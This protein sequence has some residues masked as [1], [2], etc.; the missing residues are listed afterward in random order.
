VLRW[1][2][3]RVITASKSRRRD[4]ASLNPS[5]TR[6]GT[7]TPRSR[8][9]LP[10]PSVR[11][12]ILQVAL[13]VTAMRL[14]VYGIGADPLG[15]C[16]GRALELRVRAAQAALTKGPYTSR[17]PSRPAAPSRHGRHRVQRRDVVYG[18][19][20]SAQ[21]GPALA[22]V[23]TDATIRRTGC[24][25]APRTRNR[26]WLR[27]RCRTIS[28]RANVGSCGTKAICHLIDLQVL[29]SVRRGASVG[30]YARQI[31]DKRW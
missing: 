22:L 9:I 13:S 3:C 18:H 2:R 4:S 29:D 28:S 26:L 14:A 25:A 23:R 5:T 10:C 21:L 15:T 30:Q 19:R 6:T 16:A 12:S 8:G 7:R 31:G 24:G 17:R 11:L 1:V 20:G 27:Q